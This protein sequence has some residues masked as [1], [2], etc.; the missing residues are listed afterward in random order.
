[1]SSRLPMGVG[2]TVRGILQLAQQV[3]SGGGVPGER[4]GAEDAGSGTE[5]RDLDLGQVARRGPGAEDDLLAGRSQYELSRLHDAPADGD[6]LGVEDVDEPGEADA[7]PPPCLVEHRERHLVPFAGELRDVLAEYLAS[8]GQ[9]P[10]GRVGVFDRE[11][12]GAASLWRCQRRGP[13]GSRGCRRRS[14]AP[15]PGWS[16]ARARR[17]SP[18]RRAS[19]CRA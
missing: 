1:M 4:R 11:L 10:E 18:A 16:R 19:G 6:H 12:A 17:P 2:T 9:A 7:E 13:P 15:W 5:G 8:G 3:L 14:V